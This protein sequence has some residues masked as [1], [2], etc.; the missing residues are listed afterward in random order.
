[1]KTFSSKVTYHNGFNFDEE[2]NSEDDTMTTQKANE[3]MWANYK[4]LGIDVSTIKSIV[5]V[6]I[7]PPT[8]NEPATVEAA[9]I[10]EGEDATTMW[11]HFGDVEIDSEKPI[12]MVEEPS[13]PTD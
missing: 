8:S 7:E 5:T 3:I 4:E 12:I 1:M 2:L 11:A 13:T 10:N 6:E 9:P